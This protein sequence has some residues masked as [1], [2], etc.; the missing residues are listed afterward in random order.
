MCIILVCRIFWLCKIHESVVPSYTCFL[1]FRHVI[2]FA[3]LAP[4]T[5]PVCDVC[6]EDEYYEEDGQFYCTVCNTQSQ[7][8]ILY[9]DC[10]HDFS[11]VSLYVCVC[12]CVCVYPCFILHLLTLHT[13]I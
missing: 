5:M 12:V 11:A 10:K 1:T 13:H 6:G 3:V 7:V 2:G 8:N 4:S 9:C